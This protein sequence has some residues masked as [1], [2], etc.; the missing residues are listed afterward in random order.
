MNAS[1]DLALLARVTASLVAVVLLAVLAARVARRAGVRGHGRG[2][3]VLDRVALSREASLA[4]VEVGGRGLVLGVGAQGVRLLSE[5]DAETVSRTYP[6]RP[7]DPRPPRAGRTRTGRTRTP[8]GGASAA[9]RPRA[10]EVSSV[11]VGP[12]GVRVT[13]MPD[14]AAPR[15][16]GTGSILDPR[17]WGQAIDAVRDLT[18]RRR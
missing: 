15:P 8:R 17:T 11:E 13:R 2:L 7:E 14:G 9:P 4:V 10:D 5:L 18:A 12:D 16:R 3:H 6:D 1:G